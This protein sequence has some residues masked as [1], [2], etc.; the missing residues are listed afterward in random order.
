MIDEKVHL[1]AEFLEISDFVKLC[2]TC[3]SLYRR[4]PELE[5][6]ILVLSNERNAR[7]AFKKLCLSKITN[8][9]KPKQLRLGFCA[10]IQDGDL[11]DI[12]EEAPL[13]V[14]DINGCKFTD[15]GLAPFATRCRHLEQFE[16]YWN[17][18]LTDESVKL[19]VKAAGS[20]LVKVNISGCKHISDGTAQSISEHCPNVEDLDITR[21]SAITE[22]GFSLLC[23]KL[24]KL[25]IL[26][27]IP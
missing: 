14:L 21:T 15:A 8:Y 16:C 9:G 19:I 4:A 2:M 25:K 12:D 27:L 3:D 17:V 10:D 20:N 13:R 7:D 26:R 24:P 18:R 22:L 23:E 1:F 11:L 6:R 5:S